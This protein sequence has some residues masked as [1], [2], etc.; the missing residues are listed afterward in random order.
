MLLGLF[1]EDDR[2]SPYMLYLY[3]IKHSGF[4]SITHIDGTCRLQTVTD[5]VFGELLEEFGKLT[6]VPMLLNTS[7]NNGGKPICGS[8]NDAIEL[9][10]RSDMN[11]L[12][13][14]NRI[15]NK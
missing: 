7:L 1:F 12:V 15:L 3:K 8:I 2:L 10:Y 9:Y 6:G 5:G 4:D 14:G 13:A 11:T